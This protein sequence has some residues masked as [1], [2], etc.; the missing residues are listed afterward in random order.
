M[1]KLASDLRRKYGVDVLVEPIDLASP[2]AAGTTNHQRL[3]ASFP[4]VDHSHICSPGFFGGTI[5]AQVLWWLDLLG[6]FWFLRKQEGNCLEVSLQGVLTQ[7]P[8][9][10]FPHRYSNDPA[11]FLD[12][13]SLLHDL[14]IDGGERF[15]TSR[16]PSRIAALAGLPPR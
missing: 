14:V 4:K 3:T 2:G 11:I 9:D 7:L 1:E 15:R 5:L 12:F 16:A 6:D 8:E 13:D 10:S